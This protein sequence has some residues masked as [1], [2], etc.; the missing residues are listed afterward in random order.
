MP[1]HT[2]HLGARERA[3]INRERALSLRIKG[4]PLR[5]IGQALGVSHTMARKYID[6]SMAELRRQELKSA[7]DARR[8]DL[9]RIDRALC[10]VMPRAEAGDPKAVLALCRLLERRSKLLGLDAPTTAPA[11]NVAVLNTTAPAALTDQQRA[12]RMEQLLG[13]AR[14][15]QAAL[16]PYHPP[17]QGHVAD[18]AG[19]TSDD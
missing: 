3:A 10:G 17:A 6:H 7:E 1:R 4:L 14:A 8:L 12:E 16:L 13:R 18:G 19:G 2:A 5:A 15:R 9:L 11:V